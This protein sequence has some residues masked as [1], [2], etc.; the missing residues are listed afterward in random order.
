L[1]YYNSF[2]KDNKHIRIATARAGNVVGGGD[3]NKNRLVPDCIRAWSNKKI[4]KIKNP[5]STRPWQHVLEPL[6]AYLSLAAALDKGYKI[7]GESFNIGP[8]NKNSYKVIDVVKLMSKLWSGTKWC[9]SKKLSF[10][11]SNLLKLN[12]SK[13]KEKIS[14]NPV[15]NFK[16]SVEFTVNWYK[17]FNKDTSEVNWETKNQIVQYMKIKKILKTDL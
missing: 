3:W 6:N 8:T 4:A 15:L 10:K 1:Y 14:W 13:I 9:I 16:K 12:S 2:F 17:K 5:K 11:E 7:N